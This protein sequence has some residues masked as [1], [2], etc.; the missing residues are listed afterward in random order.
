[1]RRWPVCV[2]ATGG[3]GACAFAFAWALEL[4]LALALALADPVWAAPSLA[5]E[6]DGEEEDEGEEEEE[7]GDGVAGWLLRGPPETVVR[8][9]LMI[10][11]W[12]WKLVI[13]RV[14]GS[15]EDDVDDNNDDDDDA[16]AD[17][18]FVSANC[19]LHAARSS[20]ETPLYWL[21]GTDPT[22]RVDREE[23]MSA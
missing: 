6:E 18:A 9:A 3:I 17:A 19:N 13:R 12:P 21:G 8:A 11:R 16:D 1:V 2:G 22:G 10:A 20:L 15:A 4:A 7:E 5:T 14:G 23:H